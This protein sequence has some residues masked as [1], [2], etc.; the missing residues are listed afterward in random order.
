[1][2]QR[3]RLFWLRE[4]GCDAGT[5]LRAGEL[6][7]EIRQRVL[8]LAAPIDERGAVE[9][10]IRLPYLD[11]REWNTRSQ[12]LAALPLERHGD[13]ISFVA[14]PAV[15]LRDAAATF[16]MTDPAWLDAPSGSQPDY[17]QVWQTVSMTL[18]SSLRAW[19]PE[20]YFRDIALYENHRKAYPML[21]YQAARVCHGRPRSEFT[22]SFHDYPACRLTL[23]LALKLNG[24]NLQAILAGVEERLSEAG[25]PELARRY[26][27][28]WYKD[29]V[30]VARK[31]PKP[32]LALLGAES[33]FINAVIELNLDRTPTGVHSFSKIANRALRRVYGMDLRPMGVRALELATEVLAS[34]GR[35]N[36]A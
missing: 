8:A 21:V 5:P 24:R 23:A 27:P 26:A 6:E 14:S 34:A 10:A 7:P 31:R 12:I 22:Y 2:P 20:K 1:M 18:Q 30:V 16:V 28:V 4:T 13:V 25:M 19:I 9:I 36:L 33:A 15:A 17:F 32:F 29:L 11:H 35:A 3:F